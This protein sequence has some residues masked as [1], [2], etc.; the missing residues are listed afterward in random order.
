MYRV[1][2][3]NVLTLLMPPSSEK[4]RDFGFPSVY[5]FWLVPC[6]RLYNSAD[7]FFVEAIWF[8]CWLIQCWIWNQS[9][10]GFVCIS[11]L[12]FYC[13]FK[14]LLLCCWFYDFFVGMFEEKVLF[15]RVSLSKVTLCA[16]E[17]VVYIF[18]LFH[19]KKL[20][21]WKM[22][23]LVIKHLSNLLLKINNT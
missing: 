11:L 1:P 14:V 9:L 6:F 21:L 12:G 19:N 7:F 3:H 2:R 4:K 10:F 22:Y 15:I 5:R 13:L 17:L 20:H 8:I 16:V 18:R 23:L